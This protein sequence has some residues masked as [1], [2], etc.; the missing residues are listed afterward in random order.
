MSKKK[1]EKSVKIFGL[2]ISGTSWDRV[3]KRI[4]DQR[5]KTLIVA[6]V[7][8]EFIMETRVNQRFKEVLQK[9]DLVVADGWGL[10]WAVRWLKGKRIERIAGHELVERILRRA[11]ERG[12]KVF[13]LGAGKGVAE[14]AGERMKLVYPRLK[15]AWSE[16]AKNVRQESK[17]ER[18]L[19]LAK[20]NA[21]EPDYLLVA[22]GYPWEE[23]WL[24]RNRA[25]L[26]VRVAM[27]IGGVLDEWAGVVKPAPRWMDRVGLRWLWRL[28]MQ[29]RKRWRRVMKVVGFGVM[30]VGVW[31]DSKLK[32]QKSKL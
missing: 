25:Y 2:D 10:V 29:P 14:R 31:L 9:A 8:P 20:I 7:N 22:Y 23:M 3:L 19:V 4:F 28:G 21:F 6:T 1:T 16:G 17:E 27:G 15:L 30:V 24:E 5:K 18:G 13:L 32:I 26:K 11:N 12:E